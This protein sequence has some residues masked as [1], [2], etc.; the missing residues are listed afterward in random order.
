MRVFKNRVLKK[1][2]GPKKKQ[3]TGGKRKL[4]NKKVHY[5]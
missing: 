5:L 2:F 3:V 4:H 1:T